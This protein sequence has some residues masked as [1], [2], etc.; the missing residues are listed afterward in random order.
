MSDTPVNA[1]ARAIVQRVRSRLSRISLLLSLAL[2]AAT[3]LLISPPHDRTYPGAIPWRDGS[4][5][6]KVTEAMSLGGAAATIRGVEIKDFAFHLA[7]VAGLALLAVR[8]IALGVR[9]PDRKQLRSPWLAAQL[10][11]AGWVALSALSAF[12]SHDAEISL[13][14]AALYGLALCWALTLAWTLESRDI[15][16]LLGGLVAISAVGAALCVWYYYERN[17]YHRPGFPVGNPATLAACTLPA[18]LAALCMLAGGLWSRLREGRGW[19]WA[20]VL[21]AALALVPLCWCF[22]L[23][24]SRAAMV[25]LAVGLAVGLGIVVF[26]HV[27]RS[28]RWVAIAMV[29]GLALVGLGGSWWLYSSRLDLAMARGATVRFRLYAWRYAADMWQQRPVSGIGAGSYTRL[30]ASRSLPDQALDPGAFMGELVEHAHNE[31]F[32]VL[33]EI[34]L[35]GGLTF[36]G[37]YVATFVAAARLP[38]TRFGRQRRW[39]LAALIAGL[40]ALLGDSMG[41]VG[42]RLPGMPPIFYT[43]LGVLWAACRCGAR[44]QEA[45]AAPASGPRPPRTAPQTVGIATLCLIFAVAGG[46]L[47]LRNWSGVRHEQTA[48]VAYRQGRYSDA[49]Q[50]AVMAE[51]RL[52]DPVRKLGANLRSVHCRFELAR[53]EFAYWRELRARERDAAVDLPA[54]ASV[55]SLPSTS[56]GERAIARCHAAYFAAATLNRRAPTFGRMTAIGARCAEMLAEL[57]LAGQPPQARE[58]RQRA[59][60][61]WR[62]QRL[63]SP[64]DVEALLALT[65]YPGTIAHYMALLRDALRAGFTPEQQY[66][67]LDALGNLAGKPGFEPALEAFVRDAGPFNSQT[68]LNSLV[69][70]MAPEMY[71]LSAAYKYACGDFAGAESDAAWAA[72]LYE[73]MRPRFPELFS[74]ALAYQAEYAF[75]STPGDPSRAIGLVQRAIDALPHIQEQEYEELLRPFRVRLVRYLLVAGREEEAGELLRRTLDDESAVASL[76]ANTYVGLAQT[77]MVGPAALPPD[78]RPPVRLWLRAALCLQPDHWRA[79]SWL[80]WLE[81]EAGDGAAIESAL[82]EAAAAGVS[83]E[84]LRRIRN[85]LCQEFP[86]LREELEHQPIKNGE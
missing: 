30:A 43:L 65:S 85:S 44:E 38:R 59:E 70:S 18:M 19:S 73:P 23:T 8:V 20:A 28:G 51:P 12:W 41:S 64:Y 47:T 35:L 53:A 72:E 4:L 61:A 45:A 16:W 36:V 86:H 27:G 48:D 40:A 32:E 77:F 24:G 37:G 15:P 49:G 78:E 76:L 5:L 57:H 31:L 29:G 3:Y 60:E 21:G 80:V 25:G 81:A 17:P 56:A 9:L 52:L 42:L 50:H 62:L 79:W 58:W 33:A 11:L 74:V 46:W 75:L 10:L 39:L 54:P 66:A 14:Q 67:W 84:G 7:V 68:D 83:T 34:G 82:R 6:K 1:D 55:P 2:I 13:A 69:T 71:R 63:L 26:V 22:K